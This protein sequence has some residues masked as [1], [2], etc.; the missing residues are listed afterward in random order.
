MT[1]TIEQTPHSRH[2]IGGQIPVENPAT[3][4]V[5]DRVDDMDAAEVRALA[6]TARA[7]QPAWAALGFR[8]RGVVLKRM[9]GWL[10]AHA[11]QVIDVI[12]AETGK[13]Y[14]DAQIT[15]WSYGLM[16]FDFWAKHAERYLA[17]E[18]VSPASLLNRSSG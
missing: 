14:D 16:A 3:G 2:R 9:A 1:T 6:Q 15:D 7:G 5:I 11:E 4:A 12:C 10:S 13:T 8:G 17:D 18:R